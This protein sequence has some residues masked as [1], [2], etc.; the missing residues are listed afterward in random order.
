MLFGET[1]GA[2]VQDLGYGTQKGEPNFFVFDIS[3]NGLY[4]DYDDFAQIC[5]THDIPRAHVLYRGPFGATCLA[6]TSGA[7]TF[8]GKAVHMREGI[9]I[10]PLKERYVPDLGRVIL[11]SVNEAYLLRD[12]EATEFE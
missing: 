12:G 1:F 10:R 4:L 7:E 6:Y 5:S 2:G 3:I 9:V 8:S 11:K